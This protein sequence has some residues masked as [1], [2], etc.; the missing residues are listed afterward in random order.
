M[1]YKVETKAKN[2]SVW[3]DVREKM[4]NLT[5]LVDQAIITHKVKVE[6]EGRARSYEIMAIRRSIYIAVHLLLSYIT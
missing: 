5:N 6:L 3:T 2:F 4:V 1:T